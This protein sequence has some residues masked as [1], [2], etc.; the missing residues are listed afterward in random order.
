MHINR[1]VHT[2]IPDEVYLAVWCSEGL[3]LAAESGSPS[4][5]DFYPE[6]NPN[7]AVAAAAPAI[8]TLVV[9]KV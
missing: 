1:D 9:A 3:M 5:G 7:L 6:T 2:E 4:F 8:K